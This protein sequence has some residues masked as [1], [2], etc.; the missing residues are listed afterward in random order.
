MHLTFEKLPEAIA[1]LFNKLENIEYLLKNRPITL[2]VEND[3]LLS[4]QEAAEFLHLSVPTIYGLVSNSKLPTMKK[5]KRLYF[6]KQE[7]TEWI[8]SGKKKT[9]KETDSEVDIYLTSLKKGA[10]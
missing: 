5:G 4:V 1:L 6:S 7:L 10:L 9:I 3:N 2:E 8:K